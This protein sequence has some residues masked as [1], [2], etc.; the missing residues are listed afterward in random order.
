MSWLDMICQPWHK[1]V[2]YRDHQI[3]Q[4]I[5]PIKSD[6]V[7]WRIWYILQIK[8]ILQ[9]TFMYKVKL[10]ICFIASNNRKKKI[11]F[12]LFTWIVHQNSTWQK[13]MNKTV[14]QCNSTWEHSLWTNSNK[15]AESFLQL[16]DFETTCIMSTVT[17]QWL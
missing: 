10:T 7:H 6:H 3:R 16:Y 15:P 2:S 17:I 4:H 12:F 1:H 13:S 5:H 9:K 8:M 11:R 14:H